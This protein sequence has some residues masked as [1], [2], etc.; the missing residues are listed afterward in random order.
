MSTLERQLEMLK[1]F[2]ELVNLS[3]SPLY[4]YR[5]ENNYF[6]VIGEGNVDSPLFFVGET[7]GENE[8]KRG[9]P[10]C[11]ASGYVLEDMLKI[12]DLTRKDVYITNIIK[13]RTP[14]NRDPSS[15]ELD[16]YSP[17]LLKQIEIV[18]PHIIATLGRYSMG[19]IMNH[20]NVKQTHRSINNVH[21]MIFEGEASYG[22][23]K[24]VPLYHPTT[25][26]YNPSLRSS[27]ETDFRI[28]KRL[29]KEER[30]ISDIHSEST[31]VQQL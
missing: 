19:F 24:I 17:Y 1:L 13:D 16:V 3:T 27:L 22:K 11:G 31:T 4:E 2:D 10:F 18:Q 9:R 30:G 12:M 26:L 25:I 5:I 20:F 6:P 15:E 14:N 28:L 7:P 23:I 29:Y 21:G 8:A